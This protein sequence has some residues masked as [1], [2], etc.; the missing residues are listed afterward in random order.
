M[1]A[2]ISLY[3]YISLKKHHSLLSQ[4][5]FFPWEIWIAFPKESKLWPSHAIQPYAWVW[6]LLFYDTDMGSLTCAQTW[7][8]TVHTKA[9]VRHK[10]VCTRVDSEGQK[11]CP[12]PDLMPHQRIEPRVFGFEFWRTNHWATSPEVCQCLICASVWKTTCVS[13]DHWL[14]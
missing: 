6:G 9:G 3:I 7:V 1:V 12:S 8:R 11:N 14:W 13:C 2:V 5:E 4:W 10:Q